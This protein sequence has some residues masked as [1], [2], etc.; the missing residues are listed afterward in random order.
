MGPV[1]LITGASRGIGRA[2][3]RAAAQAG[4]D[5]AIGYLHDQ[6][7]AQGAAGEVQ[8][9]GRRATI[10]RADVGDPAAVEAMV[11]EVETH[12]GAIDA[13]VNNAGGVRRVDTA[14]T[15]LEDWHETLRVN[16]TGPFLCVKAVL[17]GMLMRRRGVIV[18][19]ASIAGL[20]GGLMGPHYAAAK[21]GVVNLTRYLARDLAPHGIRVNA[22]APTLTDTDLVRDLGLGPALEQIVST[23]PM[24][25]LT[26]PEEV[27]GVIVFLLSDRASYVSGECIRIVG[28]G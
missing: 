13:L 25:R 8:T 1:V 14:G 6:E 22:V 10:H 4:Y 15:S 19:V 28:A 17:P 24:K 3:A 5:V 9:L 18:N 11:A 20:T 27:A 23:F 26:R 7:A 16:L 12:L 2:T 21:G